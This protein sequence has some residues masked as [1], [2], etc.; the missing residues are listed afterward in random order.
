[1]SSAV[2]WVVMALTACGGSVRWTS[3]APTEVVGGD[4]VLLV[5]QDR[6]IHVD[7]VFITGGRLRGRVLHAWELP[8]GVAA[9]ADDSAPTKIATAAG[10]ASVAVPQPF[11]MPYGDIRSMRRAERVSGPSSGTLFLTGAGAV[12]V[13]VIGIY[14]IKACSEMDEFRNGLC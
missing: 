11:E 3:V 9:I 13:I 5:T 8:P 1:M 6:A 4:E 12:L 14:V 7:K 10:W 2:L